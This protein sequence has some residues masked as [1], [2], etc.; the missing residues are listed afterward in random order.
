MPRPARCRRELLAGPPDKGDT[1]SKK[2]QQA[3]GG[4][5][6]QRPGRKALVIQAPPMAEP[7]PLFV[8]TMTEPLKAAYGVP[9]GPASPGLDRPSWLTLRPTRRPRGAGLPESWGPIPTCWVLRLP[10]TLDRSLN[11]AV[12]AGVVGRRS[13]TREGAPSTQVVSKPRHESVPC[14]SQAA[15]ESRVGRP[16]GA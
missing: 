10:I 8:P 11:P 7:R 5:L 1:E 16:A 6:S 3:R 13:T 2:S 12:R 14:P 4:A 15:S 9:T